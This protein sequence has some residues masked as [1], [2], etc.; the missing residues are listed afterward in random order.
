[1][2]SPTRSSSARVPRRSPHDG[3]RKRGRTSD[4]DPAWSVA[5]PNAGYTQ[6]RYRTTGDR[7]RLGQG[8]Q[9]QHGPR[10]NVAVE[11]PEQLVVGHLRD[12]RLGRLARGR[13]TRVELVHAVREGRHGTYF[14]KLL[15]SVTVVWW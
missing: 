10:R 13:R 9:P 14:T 3:H 7:T 11:Q 1:M 15:E 2:A 6:P 4:H 5:E 12:E 8:G